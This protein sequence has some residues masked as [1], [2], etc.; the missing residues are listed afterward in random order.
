MLINKSLTL[1]LTNDLAIC[2]ACTLAPCSRHGALPWGCCFE[3]SVALVCLE[4]PRRIAALLH[5]GRCFPCAPSLPGDNTMRNSVTFSFIYCFIP[6]IPHPPPQK[7]RKKEK[8]KAG[9]S[10]MLFFLAAGDGMV[11]LRPPGC[12]W[13]NLWRVPSP[14]AHA[15]R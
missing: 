7:K 14:F 4:H 13:P 1:T 10:V 2:C 8:K 12:Q 3:P 5:R 9:I 15:P 11:A 6:L